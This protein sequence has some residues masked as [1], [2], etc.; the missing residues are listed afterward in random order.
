MRANVVHY[1]NLG[2]AQLEGHLQKANLESEKFISGRAKVK[3]LAY[4]VTEEHN[5]SSVFYR[6]PFYEFC[7][8]FIIF[9]FQQINQFFRLFDMPFSRLIKR[10]RVRV[11]TAKLLAK[12]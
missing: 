8:Q 2:L 1:R 5:S 11:C 3:R 10:K 9:I 7:F 6:L 12:A 4:E